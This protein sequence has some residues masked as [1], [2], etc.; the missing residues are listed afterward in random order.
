M[1]NQSGPVTCLCLHPN[2]LVLISGHQNGQ[3][4]LWNL[5]SGKAFDP[6]SGHHDTITGLALT[7]DG[8]TLYSSDAQGNL[9]AWDLSTFLT[10]RL[11]ER[12]SRLGTAAELQ[13][14]LKHPHLSAT[15]KIWLTFSAELARWRQRYD[16]ELSDFKPIQTGEFDI[17]LF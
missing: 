4:N 14:R 12:A 1:Q 16:I 15:E 11:A 2:D 6:L 10:I 17:E 7:Q 3:T 8:T 5:S 13:E 9:L